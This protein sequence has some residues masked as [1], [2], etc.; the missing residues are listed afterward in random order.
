MVTERFLLA[1]NRIDEARRTNSQNGPGE[2]EG[3]HSGILPISRV[4]TA[5]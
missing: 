3:A 2:A 5:S 1:V 4:T